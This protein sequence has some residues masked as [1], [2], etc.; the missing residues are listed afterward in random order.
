MSIKQSNHSEK[1][2]YVKLRSEHPVIAPVLKASESN[3][4]ECLKL[5]K[6]GEWDV[7]K[8]RLADAAD[9]LNW[10]CDEFS[11]FD[12][13]VL[14]E[15]LASWDRLLTEAKTPSLQKT[16]FLESCRKECSKPVRG[17]PR[18]KRA[19][20]VAALEMKLSSAK[21]SWTKV[22]K[23]LCP[24]GNLEHDFACTQRIRQSV[25]ALQ[26]TLRKLN[27]NVSTSCWRRPACWPSPWRCA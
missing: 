12:E 22:T 7:A 10:L 18:S 3:L 27:V 17:R 21:P 16:K 23:K 1:A 11:T 24:C 15:T 14:I 20:A 19:L 25:I 8:K 26:K 4:R 13:A 6:L 9:L 2:E 5:A